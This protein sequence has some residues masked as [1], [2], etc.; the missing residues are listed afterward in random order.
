[1]ARR[2][3]KKDS[4]GTYI[5]AFIIGLICFVGVVLGIVFWDEIKDWTKGLFDK[6]DEQVEEIEDP[7]DDGSSNGGNIDTGATV[8][9]AGFVADLE[10]FTFVQ[11]YARYTSGDEA[12][13][14][15]IGISFEYGLSDDFGREIV[16]SGNKVLGTFGMSE[17]RYSA[18]MSQGCTIAETVDYIL[19]DKAVEQGIEFQTYL[20]NRYEAY[21]DTNYMLPVTA[22][23]STGAIRSVFRLS[24]YAGFD[25]LNQRCT[26]MPV[27]FE[28][29]EDGTYTY[30]LPNFA[31]HGWDS[32]ELFPSTAMIASTYLNEQC[33]FDSPYNATVQ[34]VAKRT[35]KK[36][37]CQAQG[38]AE[39]EW[40]TIADGGY[41]DT[42][43]TVMQTAAIKVGE[44]VKISPVMTYD[45]VLLHVLYYSAGINDDQDNLM[46][47]AVDFEGNVTGL[48]AGTYQIL[49][50][51]CGQYYYI[52]V[53]VMEEAEAATDEVP[54]ETTVEE[55]AE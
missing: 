39:S 28:K 37:I 27:V 8:G 21:L 55:A 26:N 34:A 6:K 10:E 44:T 47:V 51:V 50:I 52:P 17:T 1:M 5:V 41:V 40:E 53:S 18:Y 12:A 19:R 13:G 31:G 38:L 36:A 54:D 24:T 43:A 49:M 46:G 25:N 33:V 35:V 9:S 2:Y 14:K 16:S 48:K 20:Q 29:L 7:A 11:S 42:N 22:V 15:D 30:T 45:N 4:L 32:L 23:D 3:Y